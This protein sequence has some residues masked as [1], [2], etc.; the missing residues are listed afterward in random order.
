MGKLNVTRKV[1]VSEDHDVP[2]Y[3]NVA[4]LQAAGHG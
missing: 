4:Q 2:Q 1:F 3:K